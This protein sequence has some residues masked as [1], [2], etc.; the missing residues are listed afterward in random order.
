MLFR[1]V[2]DP[3]SDMAVIAKKGSQL[4]KEMREKREREKAVKDQFK[5]AGTVMGNILGVKKEDEEGPN[6]DGQRTDVQDDAFTVNAGKAGPAA[7]PGAALEAAGRA[8]EADGDGPD[9]GGDY[10]K[11]SMYGD[12]AMK[13]NVAQSEFA[14]TKTIAQQRAF[15]PI[16]GCRDH[17]LNVMRDNSVVILVGETGSGKTT[18]I[19]QY[20]M[21]DGYT[22]NGLV[23]CTQ[24]RRVAA[25]SVAKRVA[26][27]FGCRLGQEVGY[28]IR[29]E[30][31][32]SPET[33]L[34]YM[35]D[36]MLLRECLVDTSLSRYSLIMLDEA[37]ERTDRKSVV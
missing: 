20:L 30:D 11:D 3:T 10:R 9:E 15:L 2:P 16:F 5:Q 1:S 8:A 35:T 25:M 26:E 6:Q 21:E 14:R 28:S 32:T 36:G 18:Q 29:F 34:K 37:H 13:A 7:E 24:P 27:E 23:G 4:M 22:L 33:V 31:N 19:A 17:L 12:N